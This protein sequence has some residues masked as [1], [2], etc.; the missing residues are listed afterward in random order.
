MPS[1]YLHI[2]FCER[3]CIYCNFYSVENLDSRGR[4]LQALLREIDLRADQ[5]ASDPEAPTSYS[6]IFLAAE[7]HR[8]FRRSSWGASLNRCAADL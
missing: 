3:K 1:L 8:F 7:L 5:L 4:F 2:P 6:T